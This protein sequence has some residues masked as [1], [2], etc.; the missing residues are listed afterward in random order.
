MLFFRLSGTTTDAKEIGNL[1]DKYGMTDRAR[2]INIKT[3]TYNQKHPQSS[4]LFV[5]SI[6]EEGVSVGIISRR[7][8]AVDSLISSY[9]KAISVTL[10]H[11]SVDEITLAGMKSMLRNADRG[12]FI[13]DDDEVL[14][15]FGLDSI[16]Q[17]FLMYS[18]DV[19]ADPVN[20]LED[21]N[22]LYEQTEHL[23]MRESM[24][25]E[26]FRIYTSVKPMKAFGH[27]VHYLIQTDDE[28]ARG[29]AF[30][31]LVQALHANSRLPSR[32]YVSV[33]VKPGDELSFSRLDSL[34]KS[35]IGATMVVHFL[36]N[37]VTDSE[38]ASADRETLD[39]VCDL[40]KK[41][42][43]AVLSILCLP[44]ECTW[45]KEHILEKTGN[46]SFVELKDKA[47][48]GKNA[49]EYLKLLAKE[50]GLRG[51]KRLFEKIT[52]P[53]VYT[54]PELQ[55]IFEEWDSI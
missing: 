6:S 1:R 33:T 4:Y 11:T 30:G 39:K 38:Y 37:N 47:V 14:E 42:R 19:I 36:A 7:T 23:L 53:N 27:P 16:G 43:N 12:G 44:L 32:R 55:V 3:N 34:Y 5:S 17:R 29:E 41:Y 52:E 10:L 26:L 45:Q 40:M 46:T 35:S 9:L 50:R 2:T 28:K 49:I 24:N 22:R 8:S 18:E 21:K 51:D 13:D 25:D 31:I 15:R 54:A 20:N 48:S